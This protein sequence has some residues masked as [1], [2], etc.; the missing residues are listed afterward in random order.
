MPQFPTNYQGLK[1]IE[2]GLGFLRQ[3]NQGLI[4][5]PAGIKSATVSQ[6]LTGSPRNPPPTLVDVTSDTGDEL[7]RGK[8]ASTNTRFFALTARLASA[9]PLY[10]NAVFSGGPAP[11]GLRWS[12]GEPSPD[13][14]DSER[15]ILTNKPGKFVVSC[16]LGSVTKSAVLYVVEA[17]QTDFRGDGGG[18]FHSD[19]LPSLKRK[20]GKTFPTKGRRTGRNMP[21]PGSN[22]DFNDFCETQYTIKPDEFVA[23][24]NAGL[25]LKNN[26]KWL[27][28]REKQTQSFLGDSGTWVK[29]VNDV[30]FVDDTDEDNQMVDPWSASG[31]LYSNDGPGFFNLTLTTA[32]EVVFK[33]RFQERVKMTFDGSSPKTGSGHICSDTFQWH[34][35]R[36]LTKNGS[37][38][39]MESGSFGGNELLKGDKAFGP[40]P[41]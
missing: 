22:F 27:I 9:V 40:S 29:V 19:N 10:F 24:A 31:H 33:N 7:P 8:A 2:R 6:A 15:L 25:F 1:G 37:V 17:Q 21:A 38:A 13:G 35:F 12:G 16:S 20:D 18:V 28:T 32:T 41:L 3:L 5:G 39:W 23:D 11:K 14:I 34:D 4:P 36:S 30:T 26:I